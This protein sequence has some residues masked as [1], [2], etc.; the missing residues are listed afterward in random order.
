MAL[1]HQHPPQRGGVTASDM[2][3]IE[4]SIKDEKE[5]DYPE[6]TMWGCLPAKGF[7]VRHARNIHFNDITIQTESEDVRPEFVNIDT[8]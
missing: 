7:F 5:K 6:S 3:M 8:E 4:Q 2:P 1:T